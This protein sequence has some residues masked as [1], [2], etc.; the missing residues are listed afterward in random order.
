MNKVVD[1]SNLGTDE[2]R[3]PA[4]P[5][6]VEKVCPKC[7]L[8]RMNFTGKTMPSPA[9]KTPPVLEHICGKCQ[10]KEYYGNQ[11]PRVEFIKI[12]EPAA[13]AAVQ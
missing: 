1:L 12:K 2:V 3:T 9:P 13:S 10:H 4:Y 5:E 6:Y 7:K 11:Y 8:G